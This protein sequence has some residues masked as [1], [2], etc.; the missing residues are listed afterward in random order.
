M[1]SKIVDKEIFYVQKKQKPKPIRID[2]V[3]RAKKMV[4]NVDKWI[5]Q[6]EFSQYFRFQIKVIES[7]EHKEKYDIYVDVSKP[8]GPESYYTRG[9]FVGCN[10]KN[11]ALDYLKEQL[12]L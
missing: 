3:K 5:E 6:F 2:T 8:N 4:D 12:F 7:A 1:T 11:F 10:N 9:Q